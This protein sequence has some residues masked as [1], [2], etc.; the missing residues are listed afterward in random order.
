PS[1][2][3]PQV[4]IVSDQMAVSLRQD[5]AQKSLG[6]PRYEV[7]DPTANALWDALIEIEKDSAW[8][9][10]FEA[11]FLKGLIRE[12][13]GWKRYTFIPKSAARVW[14]KSL[15]KALSQRLKSSKFTQLSRVAE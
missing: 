15:R 8:L 5:L 4:E 13:E 10:Q 11:E 12:K 14:A 9:K 2:S 6:S 3:N 1:T 7:S